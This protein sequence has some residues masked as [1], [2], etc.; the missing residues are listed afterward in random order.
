MLTA[1]WPSAAQAH[2]F[3]ER[4]DLPAPLA[5]FVAVAALTVGLS[6][7]VITW[8]ARVR[9]GLAQ[10]GH[11]PL[12]FGPVLPALRTLS[13]RVALALFALL[14][15]AGFAGD[16]HPAK[17][18]A[19]T[20]VWIVWWVGLSLLTVCTGNLWPAIDPWRTLFDAAGGLRIGLAW[21]EKLAAWPAVI[22]L[23][24]FAWVEVVYPQASTPSHI[25][26]CAL[27]WTAVTLAGMALFGREA[28]QRNADP[29][30]LYFSLLGRFAPLGVSADGR[31]VL[32]RSPGR[33]LIA[34]SV[35]SFAMAAF[36]IAMLSTVLF[37]GLLGTQAWRLIDRAISGWLPQLVDRDNVFLGSVGLVAVWLLFLAAYLLACMVS[38]RLIRR[39]SAIEVARLFALCLVPIA[40]GY[41]FAHNFSYLLVQGQG[42][43]PLLSDP[44]GWGWNLFGTAGYQV[45]IG[46]V[47][48]RFAWYVAIGAIVTGHVTSIWLAHHV[49]LARFATRRE[50]VL[51]S[52]P[53]TV[54]M[55]IY[56]MLSLSIIA[57]P[58]VRFRT[59]DPSYSS[60]PASI[61]GVILRP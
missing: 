59:P 31:S 44:L 36:V 39:P 55:V 52:L 13:R 49:A 15:L 40:A 3:G 22:L 2:A 16:P 32:L 7:V 47:D 12:A 41:N 8:A 30:A 54:L 1:L 45:Q 18:L 51:S 60:I 9:P 29:F 20:L 50:A 4:Y 26:A 6:Y 37:D 23:L 56:T 48:A 21:P 25:A 10:G 27:A 33:A 28:W 61:A 42:L 14:L 19:P 38:A 53:L 57:E 35:G 46:I 58:L 43:L 5:Y 34:P 17:N 11:V 24:L